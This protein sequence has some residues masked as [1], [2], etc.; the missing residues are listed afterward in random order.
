MS[1]EREEEAQ[2]PSCNCR[3]GEELLQLRVPRWP[4]DCGSL[5]GPPHIDGHLDVLR[6]GLSNG[7]EHADE[8]EPGP[9]I[10]V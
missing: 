3:W 9:L 7:K 5:I 6:S 1:G 10:I 4:S 2:Y 8:F